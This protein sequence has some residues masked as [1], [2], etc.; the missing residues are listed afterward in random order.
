MPRPP[1]GTVPTPAPGNLT[2]LTVTGQSYT[3]W[4][5]E[6]FLSPS[7]FLS[8]DVDTLGDNGVFLLTRLPF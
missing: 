2:P 4:G 6:Y 1:G 5:M 7:V 3:V 8:Y